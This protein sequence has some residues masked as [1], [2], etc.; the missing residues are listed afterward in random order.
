MAQDLAQLIALA[1]LKID[2][3]DVV[4]ELEA[5]LKGKK[6]ELR[7]VTENDLPEAM[8]A[9]GITEFRLADGRRVKIQEE[10]HASIPKSEEARA[11]A[12]LREQGYDSIIKRDV[13]VKFGKGE[14]ELAEG[15]VN[16]LSEEGFNPDAKTSIHHSTLKSFVKDCLREGIELPQELFGIFRRMVAKVE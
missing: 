1:T 12:W 10:V 13:V 5:T 9:L 15:L 4:A 8:E 6:E 2:L 14:D 16:L 3:E 7:Q 11:F